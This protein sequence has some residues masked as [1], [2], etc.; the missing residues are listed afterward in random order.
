VARK[1]KIRQ[2][3]ALWKWIDFQQTNKD[4]ESID[5]ERKLVLN[6]DY[7]LIDDTDR[8]VLI[9][10]RSSQ[11]FFTFIHPMH[12]ILLSFFKG[13]R[14]IK[15]VVAEI[16]DFFS[17]SKDNAL[18][19]ER[20]KPLSTEK[21]LS[22]IDEAHE[23]DISDFDVTGGEIFLQKDWEIIL[24]RLRRYGFTSNLSTKVP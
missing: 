4:M 13:D 19:Q 7:R 14:Q 24:K 9:S 10:D 17:I 2:K 8:I 21:I 12:A 3:Q 1:W 20:Y 5:L 18:Q 11:Y 23:I 15:D 22:I 6:P 16:S